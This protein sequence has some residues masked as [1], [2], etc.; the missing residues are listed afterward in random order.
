MRPKKKKSR[1]TDLNRESVAIDLLAINLSP[2]KTDSTAA[3]PLRQCR[4]S[5]GGEIFH[6]V[7]LDTFDTF[8]SERRAIR[9]RLTGGIRQH[10]NLH[11]LRKKYTLRILSFKK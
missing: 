11:I 5:L 10:F 6:A 2:K 9:D 4:E 8:K 1:K 3:P 7:R